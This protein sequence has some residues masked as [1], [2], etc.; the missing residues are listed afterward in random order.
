MQTPTTQSQSSSSAE[1]H[2]SRAKKYAR[3]VGFIP[4]SFVIAIRTLVS[5]HLKN[6]GELRPTTK[7]QIAR[8]L[9]GPS[10]KAMLY[11]ATKELHG[12]YI[13]DRSFVSIGDMQFRVSNV[14]F[15]SGGTYVH[16][17]DGNMYVLMDLTIT[18]TGSEARSFSSG[19]QLR[20]KDG[21]SQV[22][23]FSLAAL[24]FSQGTVPDGEYLPGETIMGQIGF[25]VPEDAT[26]LRLVF[27]A[28]LWDYGEAEVQIN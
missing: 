17:E 12:G 28:N 16:P 7:Y 20:M 4:S 14:E 3:Q 19:M 11:Y 22:Y 26:G 23:D 21:N 9:R 6:G 25:E 10:F 27:D 13:K 2:W 15:S 1:D 5:D 8:L 18:N 24:I